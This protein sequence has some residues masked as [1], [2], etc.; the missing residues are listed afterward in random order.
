M[1]KHLFISIASLLWACYTA[2]AQE[3]FPLTEPASNMPARSFGLRLNN[4]LMPPYTQT[5]TANHSGMHGQTAAHNGTMYRLN[6]ELMW[7][8]SKN[9]MLHINL[10]ASN[11]HQTN[12]KAEGGG[13]Y[14]KYRFLSIDKVQQHF[15]LAAYAK[16]SIINNPIRYSDINLSG[17][18]SGFASGLVATQLLHKLALSITTGYT[19]GLNNVNDNFSAVQAT[20]AINYSL[21]AGYLLLPFTY[22]NYNQTNFNLYAELLGKTNP[23]TGE[24]YLDI[25]PAIQ[26]IFKSR[27]RVDVAYRKQLYGN[28]YRINEQVVLLKL[29]YNLFGAY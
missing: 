23:E 12:F 18:N 4:E 27:F 16:A 8:I 1:K 28:M 5:Q 7:G 22:K 25:A 26:F 11:M 2:Q 17:D 3:L 6:P 24:N 15:R 13:I 21:S 10:Y 14:A 19:N 9:W 20:N 29:E